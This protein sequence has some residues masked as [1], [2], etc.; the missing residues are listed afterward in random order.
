MYVCMHAHTYVHVCMH[1]HIYVCIHANIIIF[2]DIP[3]HKY[4]GKLAIRVQVL[5]SDTILMLC[6]LC[7]SLGDAG[8]L[9]GLTTALMGI[10]DL[11]KLYLPLA[12]YDP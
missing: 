4:A 5:D 9:G 12:C 3:T 10:Y 1:A 2:S 8:S 6:L 7:A 11:L